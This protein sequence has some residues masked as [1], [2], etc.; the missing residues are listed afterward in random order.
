[1]ALST[2]STSSP[3]TQ[4]SPPMAQPP[5]DPPTPVLFDGMQPVYLVRL[6]PEQVNAGIGDARSAALEAGNAARDAGM[7]LRASQQEPI[8][9]PEEPPPPPAHRDRHGEHSG[10]SG[11]TKTS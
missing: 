3:V 6:Y 7:H 10:A 11:S 8:P 5:A 1:M 9:A 2:S 4:A